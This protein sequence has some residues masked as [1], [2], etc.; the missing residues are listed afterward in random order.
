MKIVWFIIGV[1][2]PSWANAGMTG[3][4]DWVEQILT[5][6]FALVAALY[7]AHAT[8]YKRDMANITN[9][10]EVLRANQKEAYKDLHTMSIAMVQ[11]RV[12]LA[13]NYVRR[14]DVS[15]PFTTF[16]GH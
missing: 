10:L 11:L 15:R 7:A 3:S 9:Q 8:Q 5:A 16:A 1:L 4:I 14:T 2:F 12:E 6:L 13:E